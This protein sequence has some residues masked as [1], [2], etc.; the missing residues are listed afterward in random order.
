MSPQFVIWRYLFGFSDTLQF[1]AATV[2][3]V[4][5]FMIFGLFCVAFIPGAKTWTNVRWR[6]SEVLKLKNIDTKNGGQMTVEEAMVYIYGK[7]Y[8]WRQV[9]FPALL[10]K[11]EDL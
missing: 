1:T 11:K 2:D 4:V 7:N 6:T 10:A 5:L 3:F 8:S 9:L